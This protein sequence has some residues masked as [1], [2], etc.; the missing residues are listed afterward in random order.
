MS[1][2]IALEGVDG[3]DSGFDDGSFGGQAGGINNFQNDFDIT[4]K[5]QKPNQHKKRGR[6]GRRWLLPPLQVHKQVYQR[7]TLLINPEQSALKQF[8]RVFLK[9]E[10]ITTKG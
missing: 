1:E 9:G 10:R 7:L 6:R 3:V 8:I 5:T 4:Y 2:L